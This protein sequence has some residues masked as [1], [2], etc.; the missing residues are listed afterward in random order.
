[1]AVV[2]MIDGLS[3]AVG[4]A[5]ERWQ[6]HR[7]AVVAKSGRIS[8]SGHPF[9]AWFGQEALLQKAQMRDLPYGYL[10]ALAL[11]EE[12][13][14][15]ERIWCCLGFTHLYQKQQDLLFLSPERTGQSVAEASSLAEAL[16]EDWAEEGWV[17]H[18]PT[19]RFL[20]DGSWPGFFL[21]SRAPTSKPEEWSVLT[22]PFNL[23]EGESLRSRMPQGPGAARLIQQLTNGQMLLARHER[24]RQRQQEGRMP[25]NSP[26]L[27]G[28]GSGK[29][30]RTV[31][32]MAPGVCCTADPFLAGL[33]RLAGQQIYWLDE[34]ADWGEML[35]IVAQRRG[36]GP[37]LVHF[38]M[39][40]LFMR[41]R[42]SESAQKALD[43]ID[44]HF[45]KP[46]LDILQGSNS[47][48]VISAFYGAEQPAPNGEWELPWV[49]G[50]GSLLQK[51][52]RFWHRGAFGQG[53]SHPW[54]EL[55]REWQR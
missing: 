22:T 7:L 20:A 11:L 17:W 5:V 14:D 4:G 26:W 23:L 28:V 25:L 34:Q 21:L 50:E 1:M 45:V 44:Q 41:H 43:K 13:P 47:Q 42:Q 19:A 33:A 15:P 2:V 55:R 9:F 53:E 16:A 29:E 54:Q 10:A 46:V 3:A 48:L 8:W 38:A 30:L 52:R 18:P 40:A 32:E 36:S 27:W 31:S 49:M 51:S 24:N 37:V 39:P 35:S 12:L 6:W